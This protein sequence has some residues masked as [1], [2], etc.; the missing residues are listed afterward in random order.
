MG[1]VRPNYCSE[2]IILLSILKTALLS[3]EDLPIMHDTETETH[4]EMATT[5]DEFP[6]DYDPK[7]KTFSNNL[8]Y[9]GG[10][11]KLTIT[12]S[13]EYKKSKKV[14]N[15]KTTTIKIGF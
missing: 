5:C 3:I 12:I 4:H 11:N 15:E 9:T 14:K 13:E 8:K 6:F 10:C 1:F 7:T 2:V